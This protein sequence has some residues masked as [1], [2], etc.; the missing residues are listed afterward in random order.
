MTEKK[1]KKK[2]K[3]EKKKKKKKNTR[4]VVFVVCVC[5][6]GV[7]SLSV[8]VCVWPVDIFSFFLLESIGR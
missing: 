4:G 5:V 1:K 6:G 7:C 3:E 8:C 2:K